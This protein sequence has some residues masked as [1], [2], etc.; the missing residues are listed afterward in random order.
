MT[1]QLA[2]LAVSERD[3]VPVVSVA[4]EVDLTNVSEI[5]ERIARAVPNSAL[6][7]VVD[8][9]RTSFLDSA[10]LRLFFQLARRLDG[11]GQQLRIAVP[12]DAVIRKALTV[13]EIPR[14]ATLHTEAGEAVAA[15]VAQSSDSSTP[16]PPSGQTPKPAR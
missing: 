10:G 5:G 4:G 8:L 2:T 11:H 13:A 16:A 15:I 6:G 7:L 14:V 1:G 3:G 12:A 9:S